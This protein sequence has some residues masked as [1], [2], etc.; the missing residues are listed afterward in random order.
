MDVKKPSARDCGQLAKEVGPLASFGTSDA[1]LDEAKLAQ[2]N[3][4]AKK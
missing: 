4:R 3:A 1:Q 2:C